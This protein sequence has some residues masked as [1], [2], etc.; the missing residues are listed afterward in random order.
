MVNRVDPESGIVAHGCTFPTLNRRAFPSPHRDFPLHYANID[1]RFHLTARYRSSRQL[2]Y[3][4][5]GTSSQL[6]H[7]T[8]PVMSFCVCGTTPTSIFTR[9]PTLLYCAH[10]FWVLVIL[11]V[12][13]RRFW[14][15][16]QVEARMPPRRDARVM[17]DCEREGA[18]G[19]VLAHLTRKP[20][21]S[22]ISSCYTQPSFIL[23]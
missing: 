16:N 12:T 9:P 4:G 6:V 14:R 1:N 19:A 15:V 18:S 3:Y 23:A 2:H 5:P 8:A 11:F 13:R 22:S 10:C 7:A 21:H 20:H 17:D